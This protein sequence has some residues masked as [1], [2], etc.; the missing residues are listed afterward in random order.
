MSRWRSRRRRCLSLARIDWSNVLKNASNLV[1]LM[2]FRSNA[3]LTQ[4]FFDEAT[5]LIWKAQAFTSEIKLH[6]LVSWNG[7][8]HDTVLQIKEAESVINVVQSCKLQFVNYYHEKSLG[9]AARASQM[10][11]D[12]KGSKF[13]VIQR[14]VSYGLYNRLWL[15]TSKHFNPWIP[16][17]WLRIVFHFRLPLKRKRSPYRR[18]SRMKHKRYRLSFDLCNNRSLKTNSP[19]QVTIKKKK[20]SVPDIKPDETP[21]VRIFL[22]FALTDH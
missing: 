21:E 6:S 22:F 1:E 17:K 18:S 2:K 13:W 10:I 5:R 4:R 16:T 11:A 20:K 12:S 15:L 3:L 9:H 19:S 14:A 7:L 8:R